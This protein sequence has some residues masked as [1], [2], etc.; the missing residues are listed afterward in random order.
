MRTY[1]DCIPCFIRQSLDAVR[2]ITD[3]ESVHEQVL[4]EVLRAT[5]TTDLQQSPPVMAQKIHRLIRQLTETDD[6]YQQ[7]KKRFNIFALTLYSKL[8]QLTNE[9]KEPFETAVRLAVAG[10]IIDLGV[11]SSLKTQEIHGV[12]EEVLT[13]EID[14]ASF[15][16]FK[17]ETAAAKKILYLGDNAGEIVFD[18]V[19]IKQLGPDRIT[20]AVK[21]GPV[22][23]DATVEDALATGLTDLVKVIDNGDDAPG[24]ILKSC[25]EEFRRFFEEADLVIAKGQGNYESLSSIDKNI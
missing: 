25:S 13:T 11:K 20:F 1:F 19:L 21:G 2:M 14:M 9:S 3:D 24:T 10:N 23:N 7:I 15:N 6:P 12:I 4:R 22:I 18:M 8:E 16:N 17:K 5:S